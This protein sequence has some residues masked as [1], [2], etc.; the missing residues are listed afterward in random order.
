MRAGGLALLVMG[1]A[2]GGCAGTVSGS[3]APGDAEPS[4]STSAVVI[5]ERTVD[6]TQGTRATASAR[7]VRVSTPSSRLEGLRAI[8]A[9]G[10]L[11][12]RGACATVTSLTGGVA[13]DEPAPVVE[14]VDVGTVSLIAGS[15]ETRLVPRQLPDVTDVVSGVVYARATD[16]AGLPAGVRYAVHVGGRTD[17]GAF[18]VSAVAP[19]DPADI[20]VA[21]E[22]PD[23]SLVVVGREPALDLTWAPDAASDVVYVDVQPAAVRCVLGGGEGGGGDNHGSLPASLLDDRGSLVIHR[24]HRE[25]LR[26][27]GLEGGEIRFDFARSVAYVRGDSSP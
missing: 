12:A 8:G 2:V 5:V 24:L 25:P 27:Q 1:T 3:G 26:A 20:H 18:D 21:G 6:A 10:D 4:A 15:T 23:G 7:F 19:A 22:N 17:L 14:L 11:P 16:P 9:A 13:T